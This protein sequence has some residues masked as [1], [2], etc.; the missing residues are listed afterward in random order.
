MKTIK[1]GGL[2]SYED[3]RPVI[4]LDVTFNGE[5][6]E[7]YPFC[8][9][10]RINNN[11]ANKSEVLIN[12]GFMRTAGLNVDPNKMFLLS[13]KEPEVNNKENA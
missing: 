11:K 1:V 4:S 9:T 5:T 6:F 8:L 3:E 10:N 12:R 7:N 2:K 13:L